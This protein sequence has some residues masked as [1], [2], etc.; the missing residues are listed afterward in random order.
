M[1]KQETQA[2]CAGLRVRSYKMGDVAS[3]TTTPTAWN[4]PRRRGLRAEVVAISLV[5]TKQPYARY[6]TEPA[7]SI[8]RSGRA[9]A[10]WPPQPIG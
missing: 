5:D 7:R 2:T 4:Q 6:T 9:L 3:K 1:T 8:A 10:V